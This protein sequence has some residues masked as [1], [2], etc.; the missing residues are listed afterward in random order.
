MAACLRFAVY[1]TVN[2]P[3]EYTC[4]RFF[5]RTLVH[6]LR[7]ELNGVRSLGF[8]AGSRSCKLD[9]VVQCVLLQEGN[10]AV[11]LGAVFRNQK[12]Y[13]TFQGG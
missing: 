5:T 9:G 7:L 1:N 8:R 6:T 3:A 4:Y 2:Q 13:M 11:R 12:T 10:S